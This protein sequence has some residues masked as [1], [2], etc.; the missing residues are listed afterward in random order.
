ML[1]G[2]TTIWKRP[3]NTFRQLLKKK[4][5]NM[6]SRD[7]YRSQ[8]L[9]GRELLPLGARDSAYIK[10]RERERHNKIQ[11][12]DKVAG[13]HRHLDPFFF[14]ASRWRL[15]EV[16]LLYSPHRRLFYIRGKIGRLCKCWVCGCQ[17]YGPIRLSSQTQYDIGH[18]NLL[19]QLAPPFSFHP[20]VWERVRGRRCCR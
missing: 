3:Y 15:H 7:G 13:K 2:R 12:R 10:E 4:T 1:E 5:A 8:V 16:H 17:F 18:K 11:E 20:F 9:S 19:R 6:L 14:F